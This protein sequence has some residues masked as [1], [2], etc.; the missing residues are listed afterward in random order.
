MSGVWCGGVW[1]GSG[2]VL[3]VICIGWCFGLTLSVV[4]QSSAVMVMVV[5][6]VGGAVAALFGKVVLFCCYCCM[7]DL[8]QSTGVWWVSCAVKPH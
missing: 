5:M 8:S 7:G 2:V 6:C 3:Y 4:G 1:N